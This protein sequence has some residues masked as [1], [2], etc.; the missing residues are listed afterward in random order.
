MAAYTYSLQDLEHLTQLAFGSLGTVEKAGAGSHEMA[1]ALQYFKGACYTADAILRLHPESCYFVPWGRQVWNPTSLQVLSRVLMEACANF[2]YF[3]LDRMDD[4]ERELRF[5]L[6]NLDCVRERENQAACIEKQMEERG[7][8]PPSVPDD[9]SGLSIEEQRELLPW[10]KRAALPD[11]REYWK[12]RLRQNQ[13]L[14]CPERDKWLGDTWL[15]KRGEYKG[16][17]MNAGFFGRSLASRARN[18]GIPDGVWRRLQHQFSTHV[19]MAPHAVDQIRA[20]HAI[21]SIGRETLVERPLMASAA[22]LALVIDGLLRRY[23]ACGQHLNPELQALVDIYP[24]V[25]K[26]AAGEAKDEVE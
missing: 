24:R 19:H 2:H 16:R 13:S 1:Y 9:W 5:I 14:P 6:A 8:K 26:G 4:S 11:A 23:P 15:Y 18:A 17:R 7:E 22:I 10:R 25:L 21:D 20:F 3:A 12:G